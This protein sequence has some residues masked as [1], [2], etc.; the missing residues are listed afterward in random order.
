MAMTTKPDAAWLA[1]WRKEYNESEL[2]KRRQINASMLAQPRDRRP[3][4]ERA[5]EAIA[6]GVPDSE[7]TGFTHAE[8]TRIISELLAENKR[9][10]NGR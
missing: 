1:E 7:S 9:L 8:L 5:E 10:R 2:D 4:R 6:W 3:L